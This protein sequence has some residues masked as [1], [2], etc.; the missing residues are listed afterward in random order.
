MII[1]IPTTKGEALKKKIF[2]AVEDGT[3]ETW[4][5][6]TGEKAVY[7]THKPAQW[8]DRVILKF[9]TNDKALIIETDW[10]KGN[11]PDEDIKGYYIGRFCEVLLAHFRI[12][13]ST[14]TV[15]K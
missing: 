10:W 14:F 5:T 7:L 4:V 8:Y 9:T 3:L 6:R 11:L 15:S 2:D 13:F 12:D 1:T